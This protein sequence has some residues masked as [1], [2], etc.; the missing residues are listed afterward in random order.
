MTNATT[1][2]VQKAYPVFFQY[3][4]I[5]EDFKQKLRERN[6]EWAEQRAIFKIV[7]A[8]EQE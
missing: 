2:P 4:I 1:S 7:A 3:Q 5:A 8:K 6:E